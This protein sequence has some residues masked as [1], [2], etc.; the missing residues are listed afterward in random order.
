[1]E[2]RSMK[3]KKFLV[4]AKI[5]TYASGGEEQEV[6]LEDGSKELVYKEGELEYRDR[7]FGSNHFIG[8][9]I[10]WKDKKTVWGMNYYGKILSKEIDA[11]MVYEFLKKALLQVEES[12]PF[13]GPKVFN[14]GA[15]SYRNSSSG[16]INEFHGV[17][18]IL[19]Q[20]RRVY[21]LEYHGGVVKK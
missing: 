3:L 2:N 13:R 17:E 12:I 8:E 14:R 19:Y 7:Y 1:M 9:E 15:F 6:D 4:K 16:S 18:I 10:V 11:K 21:E 5:N 20:G